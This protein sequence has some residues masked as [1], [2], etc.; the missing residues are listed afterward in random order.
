MVCLF[1]QGVG[2]EIGVLK[3]CFSNYVNE[4]INVNMLPKEMFLAEHLIR[5]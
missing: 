4:S 2:S 5:N 3:G 1:L